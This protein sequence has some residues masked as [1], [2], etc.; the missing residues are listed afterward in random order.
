MHLPRPAPQ[1]SRTACRSA[2][3]SPP[4]RALPPSKGA[5]LVISESRGRLR[6]ACLAPGAPHVLPAA[7]L[8]AV[9]SRLPAIF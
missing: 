9:S 1:G 8:P 7:L 3:S 4:S 2:W 5:F 6:A